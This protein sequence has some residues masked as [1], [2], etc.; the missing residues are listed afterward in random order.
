MARPR[1]VPPTPK[2]S[3]K[4]LDRF[5]IPEQLPGATKFSDEPDLYSS[6]Q[7]IAL[8]KSSAWLSKPL[9]EQT[10]ER[11]DWGPARS[12]GKWVLAYLGFVLSNCSDIEPWFNFHAREDVVFW[13]LCG[14]TRVPAYATVWERFVELEQHAEVFERA[15]ASLIQRA[16]AKDPRVG[17]WWHVDATEAETHAAPQHD[18]LPHEPCPTRRRSHLRRLDTKMVRLLREKAD[19][20]P[21]DEDEAEVV[22]EGVRSDPITKR[23]VDRER[24]G[25]RFFS[26]GHWWFSRDPDAGTRAYTSGGRAKRAWHGYYNAKMIDHYTGGPLTMFVFAANQ[27]EFSAYPTV[28]ERARQNVGADPLAVAGDR[29]NSTEAI[30]EHNTRRGVASVFP[31]RR[32]SKYSPKAAEATDEWDEFGVPFCRHCNSGGDFLRFGTDDQRAPR[33]WFQCSMPQ[34]DGCDKPQTIS[35][36]KDYTRLLPLWRTT[37][38]YAAMRESH[39]EYERVHHAQRVRYRVGGDSLATRPKRIGIG[40]QQLRS[41][42]GLFLE[43]LRICLRQGWIGRNGRHAPGRPRRLRGM[44]SHVAGKRKKLGRTGGGRAAKRTRAQ[45]RGHPPPADDSPF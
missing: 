10:E 25:V 34:S 35:C 33:L 23:V 13:K 19:E 9:I 37:D 36:A 7:L 39:G 17:S 6:K 40:T 22:V 41:S 2:S 21:A 20:E 24:G 42:A 43:W 4:R 31:Y 26:G 1:S 11:Y 8:V 15:A 45:S 18:C 14:F 38:A 16:R 32:R 27:Q 12:P 29:G 5:S 44:S 28:Y 30:Y 3:A